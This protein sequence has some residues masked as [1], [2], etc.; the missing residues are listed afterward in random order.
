MRRTD[1]GGSGGLHD[2]DLAVDDN[3][4]PAARLLPCEQ[5]RSLVRIHLYKRIRSR[6]GGKFDAAATLALNRLWGT[7]LRVDALADLD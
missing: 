3:L 1:V 2:Q 6:L 7:N 4:V 5:V